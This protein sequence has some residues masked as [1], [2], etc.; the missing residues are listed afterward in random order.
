[1]IPKFALNSLHGMAN[2]GIGTLAP[3]VIRALALSGDQQGGRPA[4]EIEPELLE[5]LPLLARPGEELP[6]D[7]PP[8]PVPD[9]DPE[10]MPL[11]DDPVPDDEPVPDDADFSRG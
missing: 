8:A 6:E 3:G 10:A 11:V 2:F 9:V 5:P 7:E 1:L 4:V